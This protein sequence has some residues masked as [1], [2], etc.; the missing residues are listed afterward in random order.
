VGTLYFLIFQ[1]NIS[2]AILLGFYP[3]LFGDLVKSAMVALV[4]AGIGRKL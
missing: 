3:F 1:I 4:L 2:D